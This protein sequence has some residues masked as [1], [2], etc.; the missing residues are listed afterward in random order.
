MIRDGGLPTKGVEG[1]TCGLRRNQAMLGR[2]KSP[3]LCNLPRKARLDQS[4][5]WCREA[6]AWYRGWYRQGGRDEDRRSIKISFS[7]GFHS[8]RDGA[9]RL[10]IHSPASAPLLQTLAINIL[11]MP[12]MQAHWARLHLS[13]VERLRD[14]NGNDVSSPPASCPHASMLSPARR[15]LQALRL[16]RVGTSR[17]AFLSPPP[18]S[19]S[20][21]PRQ[22]NS[23][24]SLPWAISLLHPAPWKSLAAPLTLGR[25]H[26]QQAAGIA[27][28]IPNKGVVVLASR[29]CRRLLSLPPILA[30]IISPRK[31]VKP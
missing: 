15:R 18:S 22:S 21:S 9:W 17:K 20:S 4:C 19:P 5:I 31:T 27:S 30:G 1:W 8:P 11:H 26:N 14:S 29:R 25:R 28:S 24:P 3:L 23:P 7:P 2:Q 12:Q 13:A 10:G 6:L 16:S